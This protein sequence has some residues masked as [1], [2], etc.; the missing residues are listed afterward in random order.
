MII[1]AFNYTTAVRVCIFH[2]YNAAKFEVNINLLHIF[3]LLLVIQ[4]YRFNVKL[5]IF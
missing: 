1:P 3:M 2:L 4:Y 5:L